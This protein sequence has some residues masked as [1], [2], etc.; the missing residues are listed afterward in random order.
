MANH[1][2]SIKR[3]RKSQIR[4]L[5]NKYYAKTARN[6]VKNIRGTADKVQAGVLYKKVSKMLDKLA[7]KN[8]I[9]NNKANNLKSKLAL[10][11]NSLN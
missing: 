10:Y 7:K 1:K 5:R 9:H 4:R 3:I 6:A 11:V 8:V 2:S